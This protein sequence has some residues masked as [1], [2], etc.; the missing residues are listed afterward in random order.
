M[1]YGIGAIAEHHRCTEEI[2]R[3]LEHRLLKPEE[4]IEETA[5]KSEFFEEEKIKK[6]EM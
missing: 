3:G 4:A 1:A 5:L 2:L 6:E